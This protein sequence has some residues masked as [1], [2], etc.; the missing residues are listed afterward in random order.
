MLIKMPERYLLLRK[1][2]FLV[3][4]LAFICVAMRWQCYPKYI[5][6]RILLT[7]ELQK[8]LA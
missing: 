4:T 8:Q 3:F 7:Q 1:Y 5:A 2:T 6:G